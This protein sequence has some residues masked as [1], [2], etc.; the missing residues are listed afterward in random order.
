MA[1]TLLTMYARKH[2]VFEDFQSFLVDGNIL[3]LAAAVII[4]ITTAS[5][6]KT[7]VVAILLPAIYFT[8]FK[9]IAMIAP[10]TETKIANYYGTTAFQVVPFLQELLTWIIVVVSTFIVIQYF[11][12]KAVLKGINDE[13]KNGE[14]PDTIAGQVHQAQQ[15]FDLIPDAFQSLAGFHSPIDMIF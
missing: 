8:M 7:M 15:S 13:K 4:G 12:R 11:V 1:L 14:F 2:N 3:D 6:I 10:L 5:F 9:W